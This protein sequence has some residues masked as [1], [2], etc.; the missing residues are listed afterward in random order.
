[1]SKEHGY[2]Y[3]RVS[4]EYLRGLQDFADTVGVPLPKGELHN[5]VVTARQRREGGD[6]VGVAVLKFDGEQRRGE[7]Q[8]GLSE[9]L[10]GDTEIVGRN[11]LSRMGR[12]ASAA[13]VMMVIPSPD[14]S[15]Y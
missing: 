4:R 3:P 7:V 11:L 12:I 13:D 5:F 2:V 14:N 10:N 9:Q 1:M 15:V 8:L 6:V